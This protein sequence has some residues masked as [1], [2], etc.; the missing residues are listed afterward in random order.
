MGYASTITLLLL[1]II[2]LI[3]F[4]QMRL[5]KFWVFYQ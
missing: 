4:A 3:T 1:E 2:G 5:G